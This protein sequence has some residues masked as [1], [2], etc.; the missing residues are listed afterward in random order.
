MLPKKQPKTHQTDMFKIELIDL[1]NMEHELVGLCYMIR[2]N[3]ID[4]ICC[5]F[6]NDKGRVILGLGRT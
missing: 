5:K 6:F 1:I 3:E 2:W 4:E